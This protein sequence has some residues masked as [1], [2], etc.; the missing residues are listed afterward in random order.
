M[1]IYKQVKENRGI[2]TISNLNTSSEAFNGLFNDALREMMEI[3]DGFWGTITKAKL[4]AYGRSFTWP[5]WVGTILAVNNCNY[6]TPIQNN[7]YTFLPLDAGDYQLNR[8]WNS[9]I[10]HVVTGNSPV[11]HQIP[12]GSTYPLRVYRRNALDNGRT[13]T[14]FGIDSNGWE[15][16]EDVVLS[17]GDAAVGYVQTETSWQRITRVHKEKTIGYVDVYQYRTTENDLLNMAHYAPSETD[18]DYV[19]SEIVGGCNFWNLGNTAALPVGC[20]CTTQITA[21]VKRQFVEITDDLDQ[22]PIDNM[23][24]L[25]HFL[26]GVIAGEAFDP[27]NDSLH[28]TMAVK[29][30]NQQLQNKFPLAQTVVSVNPFDGICLAS[31]QVW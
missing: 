6:P 14:F 17:L 26:M 19:T 13:I 21:L 29:L 25:K 1:L 28:K 23:Q 9:Q 31:H 22:I 10:T 15:T 11:Y 8:Q 7:W 5:R 27:Q 30:L 12:C 20:G 16:S 4:C 2:Q 18:P 24:A 3:P